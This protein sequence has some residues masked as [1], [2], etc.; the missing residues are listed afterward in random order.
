MGGMGADVE[1]DMAG[2]TAGASVPP[3]AAGLLP[4]FWQSGHKARGDFVLLVETLFSTMMTETQLEAAHAQLRQF[5]A[6]YDYDITYLQEILDGSPEGFTHFQG[7]MGM[8]ALG[9]SAPAEA[10]FVAK[11]AA[12][13]V[14]DCGPCLELSLKMGR[15]AGV[16]DAILRA[17]RLDGEGLEPDLKQVHG[18][19]AQVAAGGT[20]AE[21][22]VVALRERYGSAG[23]VEIALN[24]ASALVFP[25]LKRALGHAQ[26]C[27]LTSFSV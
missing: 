6:H 4:I 19:A 10:R 8:S 13:A 5:G 11:V 24:V 27:A 1:A 14:V 18:Y 12:Y 2:T 16:A 15:E 22:T 9:S 3:S 7:V 26:S 20:P 23:L 25:A 21:A 17:A